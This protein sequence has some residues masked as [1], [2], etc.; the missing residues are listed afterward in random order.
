MPEHP[1][2]D[3]LTTTMKRSG[4]DNDP[5]GVCCRRVIRE[6]ADLALLVIHQP[7]DTV[8]RCMAIN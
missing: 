5:L 2:E 6:A 1:S 3:R 8:F 4:L 7:A